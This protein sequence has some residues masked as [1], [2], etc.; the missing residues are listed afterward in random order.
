MIEVKLN[1]QVVKGI[2]FFG[3][4]FIASLVKTE[5]TLAQQAQSTDSPTFSGV[6]HVQNEGW[7]TKKK[8][9]TIIG[10][11]GKNQRL[12]AMYLTSSCPL[13]GNL[14]YQSHLSNIGWQSISENNELSGTVGQSRQIEAV[15]IALKGPMSKTHQVE[16]RG[17]VANKGWLNWVTDWQSAGTTG[18]NR[19]L[20]AV[21]LRLKKKT[22]A[23]T[24]MPQLVTQ[25]LMIH[26]SSSFNWKKPIIVAVDQKDQPL[27]L[28][29]IQVNG[30]VNNQVVGVYPVVY[31]Y[32]Y[33]NQE[34]ISSRSLIYVLPTQAYLLED[35][36]AEKEMLRL[37]NQHRAIYHLPPLADKAALSQ[38]A[39]LRSQEL[40]Q[41]Y[42]HSR[43]DGTNFDTIGEQLGLAVSEE[44]QLGENIQVIPYHSDEGTEQMVHTLFSGWVN[45][46]SHNQNMLTSVYNEFGFGFYKGSYQGKQV[47]FATQW[48]FQQNK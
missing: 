17:H 12:E 20:E 15:R 38:A 14:I 9:P 30:S 22:T 29:N 45:S 41:N 19:Q 1:S 6:A 35:R 27:S 24:K 10:T 32:S 46:A 43:P 34:V 25:N 23:A 42:G 21:Q 48:L 36:V 16:Y 2:S 11:V 31:S 28:E 3:C 39:R 44:G 18:E 8:L 13:S 47:I 40:E 33:G 5:T 37:V 26:Q 4:L 7:L